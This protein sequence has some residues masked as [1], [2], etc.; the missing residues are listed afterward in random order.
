MLL[1]LRFMFSL[2]GQGRAASNVAQ[3]RPE[4]AAV[5]P[6]EFRIFPDAYE[7]AVGGQALAHLDGGPLALLARAGQR[8][9]DADI[10]AAIE[11][12]EDWLMPYS[13]SFQGLEMHVTETAGR[14]RH[15]L[16]AQASFTPE[17]IERAF[18]LAFDDVAFARPVNRDFVADIVLLRELVHHGALSRVVLK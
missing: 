13:K 6:L 2:D 3:P 4:G 17:E 15:R 9:R 8:L 1:L 12:S 7:I 11:R 16:G 18:S 10:E 5:S 14:L